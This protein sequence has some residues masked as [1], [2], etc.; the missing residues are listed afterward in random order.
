MKKL[1]PI[2]LVISLL[3]PH[4]S[5]VAFAADCSI[6]I[7]VTGNGTVI[8]D[9][10]TSTEGDTISLF[11]QPDEGFMLRRIEAYY[12]SA[13][14][15]LMV[16]IQTDLM[17]VD[18]A[19]YTIVVLGNMYIEATF[20]VKRPDTGKTPYALYLD[21][22]TLYFTNSADSLYVGA[23][24]HS[25]TIAYLWSGIDVTDTPIKTTSYPKWHKL[26]SEGHSYSHVIIDESFSEVRPSSTAHW[27]Y[28]FSKNPVVSIEGLQYL[29]T[30]EVTT[31]HSMFR[32]CYLLTSLDVS[33]FD[34]RCVT[35]MSHM[36]QKCQELTSLDVSSFEVQNVLDMSY[37]FDGC[38]KLSCL[39]IP[40]FETTEVYNFQSMFKDC[41]SLAFIDLSSFSMEN[42]YN[43]IQTFYGCTNLQTILCD[44]IWDISNSSNMFYNC[45]RLCGAVPWSS[46]QI[47]SSMANPYTG[48]FTFS[49]GD[50]DG[51]GRQTTLDVQALVQLLLQG[52][53]P[54]KVSDINKD[55]LLSLSDLTALV[56][57]LRQLP[58]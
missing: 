37:M 52:S 47:N 24:F 8:S 29:D 34:T 20:G 25:S 5:H 30:R 41:S 14:S 16:K 18:D 12:A 42:A 39:D 13:G 2:L 55:G 27:F 33:H 6:S 50:L 40:H 48:Y 54:T 4:F 43:L 26:E 28:V 57:R 23:P 44:D 45:P 21:D 22:G 51:D 56:N 15:G 53:A 10:T 3:T 7:S 58:S 19:Q 46:E 38:R 31:M 32:N 17:R 35:D 1:L 9:K 36:F 49:N 11:I